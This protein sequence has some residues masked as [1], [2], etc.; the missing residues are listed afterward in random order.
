MHS[1]PLCTHMMVSLF[2]A[3]FLLSFRVLLPHQQM[4]YR[5]CYSAASSSITPFW[6]KKD[7]S[8]AAWCGQVVV[9]SEVVG[10]FY[11]VSGKLSACCSTLSFFSLRSALDAI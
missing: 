7:M 3:F 10:P 11:V 2:R 5:S 9:V 4:C 8:G 6:N 1:L